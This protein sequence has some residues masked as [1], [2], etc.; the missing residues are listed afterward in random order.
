MQ[1]DQ[2]TKSGTLIEMRTVDADRYGFAYGVIQGD[3]GKFYICSNG[4]F[5][6]NGSFVLIGHRY[7]FRV[8]E[9]RYATD[10]DLIDK[11]AG[12]LE[13]QKQYRPQERDVSE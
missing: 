13:I 2:A 8:V 11:E 12:R 4:H 7:R 6:R 3:D 1:D 5:F 10:I 9:F